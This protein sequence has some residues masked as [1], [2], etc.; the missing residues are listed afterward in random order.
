MA[1]LFEALISRLPQQPQRL[2]SR[3]TVNEL[4]YGKEIQRLR[5]LLFESPIVPRLG[6]LEIDRVAILPSFQI[7]RQLMLGFTVSIID[8]T[9]QP[10]VGE[11]GV[12]IQEIPKAKVH[13]ELP[14][15]LCVVTLGQIFKLAKPVLASLRISWKPFFP[16]CVPER[17]MVTSN[18]I[19]LL[20]GGLHHSKSGNVVVAVK[21]FPCLQK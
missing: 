19:T 11:L 2:L 3:A 17:C 10:I 16:S 6:G 15:S 18:W 12:L 7:P 20:C 1:G 14:L 4:P 5:V 21:R 9:L 8:C 13:P